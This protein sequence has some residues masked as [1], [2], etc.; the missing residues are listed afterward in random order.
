MI[1]SAL[2][3]LATSGLLACIGS[4]VVGKLTPAVSVISFFLALVLC[5][6]EKKQR[7]PEAKLAA[8]PIWVKLLYFLIIFGIYTHSMFLFYLKDGSDFWIQNVSNLGDLSFHW[9]VIRNLA[10]GAN[11]WPENPIYLAHRF[12]YPFGMD[13]INAMFEVL[14]VA[15]QTHLPLITMLL[16]FL[17]MASLHLAGG[18]LLVFAVFFS[19]GFY[20]FLSP[21]I[22]NVVQLQ[23]SL[24]F[25]NLFLTVLI[26]QRGIVY[27]LPAG[28]LIYHQLTKFFRGEWSPAIYEKIS[29]GIIWGSLAFFHLHSYFIVSIYLGCLILW[30]RSLRVWLPTLV[31]A[32]FLGMPFVIGAL[33]PESGTISLIHWSRGWARPENV[34]YFFYWFKNFGPWL[35]AM[36]AVMVTFY[37]ERDWKKL[38]PAALAFL[39]FVLFAHLILAPWDWDNIK[40]LLWCYIFGLLAIREKLW[41][42]RSTWAQVGVFLLFCA[43]GLMIFVHSLPQYTRGA[44]WASERE[45]NKAKVLLKGRD[46]NEGLLIAPTYDHPALLLGY[47]LYMGYPGHV[48]SHGYNYMDREAILTSYFMGEIEGLPLLPKGQVR[49]IYRGPLEKRREKEGYSTKGLSKVAE[50]LDHELYILNNN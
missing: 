21:K 42:R 45:L 38:F 30:N 44:L 15:I 29:L 20:D 47:K 23:E 11:F 27:A 48:W 49:W 16:L 35:M 34:N 1:Q 7:S 12:K 26:T 46:V 39:L 19:A 36:I 2:L 41:T 31:L 8:L 24:D 6:F 43:P 33:L 13:L 22:W 40:L 5:L 37:R 3:F 9:N 18:P 25:K 14:G 4:L 17:T 28:L 10:G 50:A 32:I